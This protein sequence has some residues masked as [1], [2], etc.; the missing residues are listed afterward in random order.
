MNEIEGMRGPP[1]PDANL[2]DSDG[3]LKDVLEEDG[4]VVQAFSADATTKSAVTFVKPSPAS[5]QGLEAGGA[6]A[7]EVYGNVAEDSDGVLKDVLEEEAVRSVTFAKPSP[8]S[9]QGLEAGGA[10]AKEASLPRR[11]TGV[12]NLTGIKAKLKQWLVTVRK[13]KQC[14]PFPTEFSHCFHDSAAA[15]ENSSSVSVHL[16]VE[17]VLSTTQPSRIRTNCWMLILRSVH[18]R[19]TMN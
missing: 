19:I 4:N 5:I 16:G 1:V 11:P 6:E 2:E 3:V 7:L 17:R 10:E 12:G 9:I 13:R 8:A 18:I 14:C 15:R